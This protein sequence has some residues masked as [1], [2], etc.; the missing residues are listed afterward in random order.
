M[1][2]ADLDWQWILQAL[3][4]W[5]R[6]SAQARQIILAAPR[7]KPIDPRALGPVLE[8]MKASRLFLPPRGARR[9]HKPGPAAEMLLL[10]LDAA[11]LHQPLRPGGSGALAPAYVRDQLSRAEIEAAAGREAAY[12]GF[13]HERTV[14]DQV[15]SAEWV[16]GFLAATTPAAAAA[17]ES[18]LLV[19]KERPR[20]RSVKVAEALRALVST[21]TERPAGHA[22]HELADL[23]PDAE[24]A[25]RAAAVAAG[26]RLLLVFV[27]YEQADADPR[28]G[29]L[30]AAAARFA[31]PPP[32]PAPVGLREAF[33]APLRVLDMTAI[34][35]EAA[36]A[37][38]PVKDDAEIY[39]RAQK[40]LVRHLLPIPEW[41]Q[42]EM[43]EITPL[44]WD[45]GSDDLP[46]A[47]RQRLRL[48]VHALK[49]HRLVRVQSSGSRLLL[50][51]TRAGQQWLALPERERLKPCLDALRN[52]PQR[53]PESWYRE[54]T[55]QDFFG[56]ALPYHLRHKQLDLRSA[57]TAALLATPEDA[58]LPLDAWLRH[59]A[60]TD[61][62][63]LAPELARSRE[64]IRDGGRAVTEEDWERIWMK[65]LGTF[66]VTRLVPYGGAQV[67]RSA[68]G[69]TTFRLTEAGRYVLGGADDFSVAA[70]PDGE[71]VVQPDFE[72]VFLAPAPRLEV[73]IGRFAE[74]TGSGVG[75]LFRI[76]RASVLRAAEQG[77]TADQVLGSL[78][79]VSR[80]ELPANVARQVRDWM[81]ATRQ[82]RMS[83]AILLECPDADTAARI[84]GLV[85]GKVVQLTPTLLRLDAAPDARAA[86]LKR[87]KEKGI[88]VK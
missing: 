37:P 3:P 72:V 71:V 34:L 88:F 54:S 27:S 8:E 14:A 56:I 82:V 85:R 78:K 38:L 29:L 25:I 19:A 58:H 9:G 35:V 30:P 12:Y 4:A 39:V 10:A 67:G 45:D 79:E 15:S 55:D 74:R 26:L 70:A 20:L 65:V 41:L 51:A 87:L 6:L 49:R 57:L 31:P 13:A 62:A 68:E 18:R 66:L 46:A 69:E 64:G 76:T 33:D 53:N 5:R 75:A 40:A 17:W 44:R 43:E 84:Q 22:L 61:N 24:P 21:L 32:F 86:L 63:L 28:V 47:L 11:H 83:S 7:G 52:L 59:R 60:R 80:Q 50:T 81:G 36:T 77:A 2:L 23:L 1:K 42:E 48:A 73:E 16:R